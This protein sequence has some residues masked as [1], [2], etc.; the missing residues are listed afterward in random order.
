MHGRY[1]FCPHCAGLTSGGREAE[2]AD[3]RATISQL[4]K[5]RDEAV[6]A[7]QAMEWI[8][9]SNGDERTLREALASV[10]RRAAPFLPARALSSDQEKPK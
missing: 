6:E 10:R 9:G 8:A 5:E 4:Q 7:I 3:L 2:L 1:G